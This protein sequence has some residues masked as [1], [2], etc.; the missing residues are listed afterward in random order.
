MDDAAANITIIRAS[1]IWALAGIRFQ[2]VGIEEGH[3]GGVDDLQT[4]R[5][6]TDHAQDLRDHSGNTA[7]ILGFYV[8]ED[9]TECIRAG[10]NGVAVRDIGAFYAKGN[11]RLFG[12]DASSG[13]YMVG[14]ADAVA[15]VASHEIGH[16]LSLDHYG[17]PGD[18]ADHRVGHLMFSGSEGTR[19]T[20]AEIAQSR[21]RA[22]S[23]LEG[24][25]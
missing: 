3:L 19:L 11:P 17:K 10:L 8:L 12:A 24:G 16:I 2:L 23:I 18:L 1:K 14:G 7:D 6:R 22:H 20:D 21:R 25:F 15:R 9:V 13:L 4:D 5:Q